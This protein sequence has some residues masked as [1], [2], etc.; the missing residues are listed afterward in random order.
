MAKKQTVEV[1][2]ILY[3][4]DQT[5]LRLNIGKTK[6]Y[7]EIGQGELETT[8]IGDRRFTTDEQQRAYILR[9]QRQTAA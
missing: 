6:L 5:A 7:D 9:K 3:S 8:R 2:P 1:E 4:M